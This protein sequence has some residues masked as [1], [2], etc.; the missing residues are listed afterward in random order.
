MPIIIFPT[1]FLHFLVHR[2]TTLR[3][4]PPLFQPLIFRT[5]QRSHYS[6]NSNSHRTHLCGELTISDIGKR[7]KLCG[8]I[9]HVRR[10]GNDLIFMTLRDYDGVIQTVHSTSS[11]SVVES[12]VASLTKDGIHATVSMNPT[13]EIDC[14]AAKSTF[15]TLESVI[16][17]E[18]LVRERPAGNVNPVR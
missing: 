1:H 7:V 16:S 2:S 14:A 11:L 15:L 18:G 6:V 8:W 17:V 4:F 10:I 12:E 13:C 3:S 9:Q 5:E